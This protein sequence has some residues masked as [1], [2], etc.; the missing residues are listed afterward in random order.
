MEAFYFI[1][2]VAATL[3]V[4]RILNLIESIILKIYLIKKEE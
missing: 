4:N 3:F 2:G 1:S